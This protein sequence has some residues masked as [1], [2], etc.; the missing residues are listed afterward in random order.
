MKNHIHL[1]YV[2]TPWKKLEKP[3]PKK[4]TTAPVIMTAKV[5]GIPETFQCVTIAYT[6]D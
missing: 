6:H 5:G 1:I 4:A 2:K 3:Y